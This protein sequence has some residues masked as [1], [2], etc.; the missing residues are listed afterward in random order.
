MLE[1]EF[2]TSFH[3]HQAPQQDERGVWQIMSSA[4]QPSELAAA[5]KESDHHRAM[6]PF[7]AMAQKHNQSTTA[8]YPQIFAAKLL[9]WTKLSPTTMTM[10]T[11]EH[12]MIP[13]IGLLLLGWCYLSILAMP[14]QV[15]INQRQ[16][17]CLYDTLQTE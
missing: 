16:N 6:Q 2:S 11:S 13:F 1:F 3:L 5:Q 7:A 14:M 12:K 8:P 10:R 9:D 4:H 15:T 17:E